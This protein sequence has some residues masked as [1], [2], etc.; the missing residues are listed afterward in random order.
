[1][2]I[3]FTLPSLFYLQSDQTVPRPLCGRRGSSA[4][5]AAHPTWGDGL[6]LAG[7]IHGGC[8]K[9]QGGEGCVRPSILPFCFGLEDSV[10]V[11]SQKLLPSWSCGFPEFLLFPLRVCQRNGASKQSS[12]GYHCLRNTSL[13]PTTHLGRV[14]RDAAEGPCSRG[15]KAVRCGAPLR[16]L[17][18]TVWRKGRGMDGQERPRPLQSARCP[19]PARRHVRQQN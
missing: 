18:L 2:V 13:R 7:E 5:P 4:H 10:N 8:T 1:M 12:R 15:D 17:W 16:R 14:L 6:G 3:Y 9:A 11:W 19:Y